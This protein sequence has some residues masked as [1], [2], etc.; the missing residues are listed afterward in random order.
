LAL[1][2][3]AA[4][5]TGWAS[6]SLLPADGVALAGETIRRVWVFLL[7]G[8]ALWLPGLGLLAWLLPS[9]A[10]GSRER[11]VAA[12]AVTMALLPLLLLLA[13]AVGMRWNAGVVWGVALLG[14]AAFAGKNAARWRA[15]RPALHRWWR[16]EA[17]WPDAAL[18]GVTALVIGARLLAVRRLAVPLWGDSVQ[19]AVMTQLMVDNGGLFE[20]WLPYAPYQSLTVHFGFAAAAATVQWVSGLAAP[21][22]TLLGGQIVNAVAVLSLYPL[23]V[24]MGKGNRWA[25]VGALLVGGL[26]SPLPGFYANWGRYAQLA[27]QAILPVALWLLWEAA[28]A[29]SVVRT[30]LLSGVVLAGMALNYYRVPFYV[31]AFMLAWLLLH[32]LPD[33]RLDVKRWAGLALRF[34]LAGVAAVLLIWPWLSNVAGGKLAAGLS[35]SASAPPSA[36]QVWVGYRVWRNLPTYVPWGLVGLSAAAALWAAARRRWAALLPLGWAAVLI[37]LPAGRLVRLPGANYMQH[38]AVQIAL[39]MPVALLTGW[40]LGQVAGRL[41]RGSRWGVAAVLAAT[42]LAAGWGGVRQATIV[43]PGIYRMVFPED[44]AA[45]RWIGE[46][47]PADA[48]FLVNGFTIYDG[49]S[50]V[51]SDAGWWLPLMAGRENTMP[52]QYALFN[53]VPLTSGY[54]Q[55]VTQLIH[56]LRATSPVSPEGLQILCRWEISH[57][58]VGQGEGAVGFGMQA[59]FSGEELAASPAFEL[60]FRQGRARVF[61]LE[62]QV[63]DP[64]AGGGQN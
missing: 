33:Y 56:D 43:E 5:W 35:A 30:A 45:M 13:K 3:L 26:L 27:G 58:Y 54:T 19:H 32:A 42:V 59:L 36:Q 1:L 12:P 23:A 16:S 15:A 21:E 34:G 37:A 18:L 40:L 38:F 55:A 20:S 29:R 7:A 14:G 9:R 24:K 49:R 25:G 63:C 50:S 61:A 22:A 28:E 6:G 46:N 41:S 39:Y 11:W 64:A 51:G 62:P 47:V 57:A 52:P 44:E 17:R 4:G 8:A 53:E 60:I 10:I 2:P 31:A 48:R